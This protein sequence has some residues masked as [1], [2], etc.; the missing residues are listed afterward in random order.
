[1]KKINSHSECSICY[2]K[3]KIQSSNHNWNNQFYTFSIIVPEPMQYIYFSTNID[4]GTNKES[5]N[6]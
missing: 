4:I 2:P 5:V 3:N 6:L 1:M